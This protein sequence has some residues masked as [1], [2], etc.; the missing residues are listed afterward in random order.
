MDE[1]KQRVCAVAGLVGNEDQWCSLERQWIERTAGLPFHAKDCDSDQG[2]YLHSDHKVN[3]AL[4]KDVTL[5]LANS[6]L[7]GIGV[8]IDLIANRVTV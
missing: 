6:G 8:P 4:Y 5:L 2:D 1:T 3:K 7:W